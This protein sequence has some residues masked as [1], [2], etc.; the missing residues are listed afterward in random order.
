MKM[1]IHVRRNINYQTKE[2]SSLTYYNL[3]IVIPFTYPATYLK[4][5]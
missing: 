5:W 4:N 2:S 3:N 1:Q